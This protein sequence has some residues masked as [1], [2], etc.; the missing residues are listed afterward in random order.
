LQGSYKEIKYRHGQHCSNKQRGNKNNKK[1]KLETFVLSLG[2]NIQTTIHVIN[3]LCIR[4]EK[5]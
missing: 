1:D 4:V 2:A 5:G 3:Y